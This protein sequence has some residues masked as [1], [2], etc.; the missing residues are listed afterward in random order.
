MADFSALT[1][2]GEYRLR[3]PGMG[4]SL[5]FRIDHGAAGVF[6]RAY[7]AG[8]LHQ[9]SGF[10]HRLPATRF[11]DPASHTAPAEIPA[12]L[13][14]YEWIWNDIAS[15]SGGSLST[16][17]AI[18]PM[19]RFKNTGTVDVSG[20]HHDAGDYGKYTSNSARMI[21]FLLL[22]HDLFPGVAGMDNLGLPES[23]DGIGDLLQEAKWEADFLAK[24]QDSDGGFYFVVRPKTRRFE[25]D[26]LPS[27]GDTQI[28]Y[29]KST[30]GTAAAVAALA[31]M[32]SSP[33]FQATYPT[34]AANYLTAA[35]A[36]WNYLMDV[37]A[38]YGK[39]ASFQAP[40]LWGRVRARRRIE[41]G[42]RGD[43]CRYR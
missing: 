14:G 19:L 3:V 35:T 40:S 6:A 20:G 43:V 21:H 38:T 9:R 22:A 16:P 15:N 25:D 27:N 7:A 39:D 41:L 12:T 30:L 29:P 28:V 32:G 5:P 10:D 23:G 17:E 4:A 42:R 36:G 13:E 37:I 1:T 18:L 2:A 34:A 33:S 31:E 26:V 8:L 11:T 24:M